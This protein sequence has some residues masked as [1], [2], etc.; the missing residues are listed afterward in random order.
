MLDAKQEDFRED[1]LLEVSEL[2]Q[3]TLQYRQYAA[4]ET[5]LLRVDKL[6]ANMEKEGP[7]IQVSVYSE[8]SSASAYLFKLLP[9]AHIDCVAMLLCSVLGCEPLQHA[10]FL[11][12]EFEQIQRSR[13]ELV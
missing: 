2:V 8:I 4:A 9:A 5:L 3:G 11:S 12:A 13:A 7:T 10:W 1:A 6:M